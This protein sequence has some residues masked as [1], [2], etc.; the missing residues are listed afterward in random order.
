MGTA[1]TSLEMKAIKPISGQE[2]AQAVE[3]RLFEAGYTLAC[4]PAHG[5]RP[6]GWGKGWGE[7]LMDMDDLL[8][9]VAES[10]VRPPMPTAAAITRMDEAF[11][12][13]Q[14]ISNFRHRRVVLL[15]M[16]IHPLSLRHRYSWRQI[17]SFLGVSDKTAKS[18]FFRG[19]ADI[20]KKN[21]T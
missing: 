3:D 19:I 16:M 5:V 13:V 9:L 4:L 6:A 7:T 17:G 20:T 14:G 8:T 10:E 12:W 21:Y 15:W 2:M 1:G 11:I 18:W